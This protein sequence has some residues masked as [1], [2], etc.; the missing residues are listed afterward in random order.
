LRSAV[1]ERLRREMRVAAD[2]G[3]LPRDIEPDA[4][5]AVIWTTVLGMSMRSRDGADRDE[6]ESTAL[7]HDDLAAR[8]IV[9]D[10]TVSPRRRPRLQGSDESIAARAVRLRLAPCGTR[11]RRVRR[12]SPAKQ[13]GCRFSRR[14][15][16]D[17]N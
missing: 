2:A 8:P 4:L 1:Q 11:R 6:F 12:L 17:A 13:R 14:T 15:T 3:D 10:T 5:A 16:P 7:D 9:A